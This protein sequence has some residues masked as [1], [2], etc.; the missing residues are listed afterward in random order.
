[1]LEINKIH[2]GTKII[3]YLK[4]RLDNLTAQQFSESIEQEEFE[5]IEVNCKDLD[6]ISS[7]G[8]RVFLQARKKYPTMALTL[9]TP[10]VYEILDVTG[11]ISYF[12]VSQLED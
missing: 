10:N 8:L 2:S 3:I 11:F 12:Q 1:M 7:A 9:V 6:Y 5:S 4:G